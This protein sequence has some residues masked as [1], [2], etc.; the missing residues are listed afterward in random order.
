MTAGNAGD[1]FEF[2]STYSIFTVT[3]VLT[4]AGFENVGRVL[5][6]VFRED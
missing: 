1:G 2:N 6:S 4:K 5:A 3:V